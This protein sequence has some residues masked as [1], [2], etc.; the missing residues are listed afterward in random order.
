MSQHS[1]QSSYREKLIE[2]LFIGELLKHSWTNR[3]CA[4]AIARPEVDNGG[5]DVVAEEGNVVR[6][7]QLKAAHHRAAASEQKVHVALGQKPAGCLVWILFDA[8]T[9]QLG[10]YLFYGGGS[11]EPLVVDDLKVAKHTK[12]NSKGVKA[13][14]PNIRIVPKSL[15]RRYETIESLYTALFASV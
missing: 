9:L 2:H 12:G 7:I 8:E 13:L 10:P 15:F 3:N 11:R 1:L 4:L 14:R 6:H 5:Y